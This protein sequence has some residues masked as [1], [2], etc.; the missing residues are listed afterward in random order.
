MASLPF[1]QFSSLPRWHPS[2][3]FF[4][5]INLVKLP[6]FRLKSEWVLTAVSKKKSTES[7]AQE[8][9][10]GEAV[11]VGEK[12]RRTTKRASA[13]SKKKGLSET[14][15]EIS[16]INGNLTDEETVTTSGSN[17]EVKKSKTRTRKK[18]TS[19]SSTLEEEATEKKVTR[20]GRTKQTRQ[21][22]DGVES[23]GSETEYSDYEGDTYVANL[24]DDNDQK[25]EFEIDDGEDISFTYGWP[26]LVCCFGAA[27]HAFVPSGRR[28]NRLLDYEM[29]E[30]KKDAMWAPDKFVRASGGCSSNVA[31]AL[32]SLGG[33]VA[34]M[35]KL[36]DD[37]YGH[38]LIY[39]LNINKVQTRSIRIDSKRTT[40]VSQM[41]MGKRG[42]LRMTCIKPCAEDCLSR[43]DINIDVLKEAKMFYFN[44]FS[45]LDR[46]MRL[47]TLQAIGI[48]KKL[49]G[50]IF[51]DLNLPLPLWQSS[52]ETKA[53]IQQAWNLADIIEVT[54]QELDFLC[55]I[56]PSENFD[57]KDNDRSK[58]THYAPEVVAQLWHENLTVLFVTNGTSKIH[59]YTK[60][61]NGAVNGME[62]APL[63]PFTSDMSASGDGIIAGIMRM[64]TVQPHRISDKGYLEST[65]KYAIS[66][67]VVDQWLHSRTLGF[68]PKEEMEDVVSDPNGIKS[69]TEKEYRTLVPASS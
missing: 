57:T 34:F 28:A 63:T 22:A 39:Y 21:P 5:C 48:S 43:S 68:P 15:D 24:D 62:D 42:G 33:K 26:P 50:V 25:L 44:T 10:D 51:Y 58:F 20:R 59:Y 61:H 30:R 38:A 1:I 8:A 53:F 67:G 7:L 17:T 3:H 36:G 45:L 37:A 9:S 40:A 11:V 54:K 27:Q 6:D 46:N 47:T 64:L 41:K 35:G 49:G 69:I 18:A 13:R 16:I 55:G 32:A 56:E 23:Q 31:V 60:E 14:P 19:A 65:I 2:E 4:P 66:C 52:E 12:M 29:H